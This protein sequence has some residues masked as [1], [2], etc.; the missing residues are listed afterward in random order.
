MDNGA[1]KSRCGLHDSRLNKNYLFTL[2]EN[3]MGLSEA[4]VHQGFDPC[5]VHE[6]I[7]EMRD[8]IVIDNEYPDDVLMDY[9]LEPDYIFQ[10]LNVR[11][12]ATT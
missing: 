4:L 3:T 2:K 5:Y 9:G 11:I 8:R 6:I 12:H 10:L 7:D 1:R